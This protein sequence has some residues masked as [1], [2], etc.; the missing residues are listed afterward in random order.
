MLRFGYQIEGGSVILTAEQVHDRRGVMPKD[1]N[2]VD[3]STRL[4]EQFFEIDKG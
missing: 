4:A 1:R 3:N 2:I